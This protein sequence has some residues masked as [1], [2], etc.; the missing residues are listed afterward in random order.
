MA[1]LSAAAR[2]GCVASTQSVSCWKCSR[3]RPGWCPRM[4]ES[5]TY[6]SGRRPLGRKAGSQ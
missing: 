3:G 1:A 4:C 6:E 2:R 5:R